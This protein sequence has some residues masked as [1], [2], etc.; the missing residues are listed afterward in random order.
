MIWS[1][2]ESEKPGDVEKFLKEN[3]FD[4][5]VLMD[6]ASAVGADYK[7]QGIPTTV[8][9]GRDGVIKETFLGWD[10]DK[11]AKAID[12]AINDALAE[13]ASANP[14]IARAGAGGGAA[15]GTSLP[16]VPANEGA[17]ATATAPAKAPEYT[18]DPQ[19]AL[20]EYGYGL[21][22]ASWYPITIIGDV[23]DAHVVLNVP[24]SMEAV[25]NGA[26]VKREKS[27]QAGVDG[28]FEFQTKNPVFGL[29]FAYGPYVVQDKQVGDIHFYTYFHAGKRGQA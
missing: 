13:P 20:G 2:D 14:T 21:S 23:F 16:A 27:T 3:K 15:G 28:H 26:V 19:I 22:G 7:V 10:P 12:D 29:Y 9:I 24:A 25:S 1:V 18:F 4:F 11:G 5:P 8:V 6:E 17:A